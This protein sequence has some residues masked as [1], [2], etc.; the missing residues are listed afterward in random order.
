VLKVVEQHAKGELKRALTVSDLIIYGMVYMLPIAP[1]ALFGII[2]RVAHG[3]VALA[4]VMS[5]VAL[6][7]TARSYMV[8]SKEFPAAG[9]RRSPSTPLFWQGPYVGRLPY[10]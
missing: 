2:D 7:F 5:A 1:F 6:S 10:D 4:Y 8:L 3:Y 9:S